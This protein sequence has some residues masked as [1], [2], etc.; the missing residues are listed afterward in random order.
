[1]RRIHFSMNQPLPITRPSV[2]T[3][4][5]S[6][7]SPT[8]RSAVRSRLYGHPGSACTSRVQLVLA[9]KQADF[10]FV[11]VDLG[12][13]EQKSEPHVARH[14]FGLVPVWQD[15]RVTLYESMA[16]ARYLDRTLSGVSLSPSDPVALA[17]MDQWISVADSQF[18]P[19]MR[20]LFRHVFLFPQMGVPTEPSVIEESRAHIGFV[21]DAIERQLQ[22]RDYLAGSEFSLADVAFLPSCQMLHFL[23]AADLITAR[24]R[25][26][27]WWS[28]VSTRPA[29]QRV[30]A[31]LQ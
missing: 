4:N 5:S 30:L 14:P 10:D 17:S 20:L 6:A 29:W 19:P 26:T 15:E 9:E 12:R 21:F 16:I 25:L 18:F 8:T 13:G 7:S 27:A 3:S 28:R 2:T 1:M 22:D 31:T 24:P 11:H 23:G